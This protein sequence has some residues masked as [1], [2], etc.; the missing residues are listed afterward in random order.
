MART[1]PRM[2]IR[3]RRTPGMIYAGE[4]DHGDDGEP[5]DN[6]TEH[7][8]TSSMNFKAFHCHFYLCSLMD[9][10]TSS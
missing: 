6:D 5:H 1:L 7:Y 3:M 4:D 8:L 2:L 10:S 9:F